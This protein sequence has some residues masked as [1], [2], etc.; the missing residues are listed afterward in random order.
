MIKTFAPGVSLASEA[1]CRLTARG[2]TSAPS[3]NDIDAGSLMAAVA[4]ATAYWPKPPAA[5]MNP[6][7]HQAGSP[8]LQ[9]AQPPQ[10]ITGSAATTSPTAKPSVSGPA[11]TT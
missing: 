7:L 3:S 10:P 9:L 8:A 1:P 2:S 4:L 6:A 5:P 11:S